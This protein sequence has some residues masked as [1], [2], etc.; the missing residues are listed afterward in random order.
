MDDL[1][2]QLYEANQAENGTGV[3]IDE[4]GIPLPQIKNLHTHYEYITARCFKRNPHLHVRPD[5]ELYNSH[6]RVNPT[7][8]DIVQLANWFDRLPR[9]AVL[10]V[11][12][13][14]KEL[15][16][17]L[18]PNI[19][20]ITPTLGWDFEKHVFCDPPKGEKEFNVISD[21]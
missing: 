14:I 16:P 5:G 8:D 12:N 21:W 18:D 15:A 17:R 7:L 10:Y 13:R 11:Y 6:T 1:A 2:D 19:I 4:L 20:A 3:Q 9:Q